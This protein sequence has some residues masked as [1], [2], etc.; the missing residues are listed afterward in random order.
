M[1]NDIIKQATGC[2]E[3]EVEKIEEIMRDVVFRS[4]LDWQTK[5]ELM[6]GARLAQKTLRETRREAFPSASF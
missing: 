2:N 5:E 3:S 6:E 4:T 1:Y